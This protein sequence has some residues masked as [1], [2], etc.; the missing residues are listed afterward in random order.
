MQIRFEQVLLCDEKTAYYAEFERN[1]RGFFIV[2]LHTRCA[3]T[4]R[5]ARRTRVGVISGARFNG[6]LLY[7]VLFL[8]LLGVFKKLVA[9]AH[10]FLRDIL[11]KVVANTVSVRCSNVSQMLASG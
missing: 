5:K 8:V 1:K 6:L 2:S 10:I 4:R 7:M 3:D 9:V 11:M